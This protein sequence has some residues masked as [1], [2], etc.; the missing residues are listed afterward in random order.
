MAYKDIGDYGIIGNLET[1]ALVGLDGSID[2]LCL[3]AIDSPSVF[4]ALLDDAKGGRFAITPSG[5]PTGALSGEWTSTAA[6]IFNT[7]I[8]ETTFRTKTGTAVITDFMPVLVE[9]GGTPELY[10]RVEAT[11]GAVEFAL[12]FEPRFDYARA[13]TSV[14]AVKGGIAASGNGE[15]LTLSFTAE[16]KCGPMC[17]TATFTLKKGES[18]CFVLRHGP[19]SS[20][21]NL[22]EE[23]E[24]ALKKTEEFWL[25][26]LR[27]SETGL[28]IDLGPFKGMVDRSALVLKLL[29]YGPTGA[30]AA[31]ATTSLPEEIGGVRNWD[32]RYTWIRDTS[33]ILQALYN[34]GHLKETED[35]LRWVQGLLA[36]HGAAGMQI[37]Y[38]LR[39]ETDITEEVLAHLEGYR[40]SAPVRI[41]NEAYRQRQ[42]DIYGELMDSALK[43]SNYV[44]KID[45]GM[46]PFLRGVCDYVALNWES[47]DAG[48][49]EV[50]S[51]YRS[52]T[53]SRLMCWVALDRGVAIAKRY[54]FQT[55]LKRW[56]EVRG[57]IKSDIM[58]RGWNEQIQ[59]FVGYYGGD[60]LD[61]ATLLIPIVGLL[62]FDDPR[63]V[64]N[65]EA[66]RKGLCSEGLIY[67]YTSPDGVAG[68]EGAFLSCSFWFIDS[69]VAM[70]RCVEAESYLDRMLGY[71][72]HLG[73]FSEE[74]DPVKSVALGN[75]PQAFTHIGFINSVIALRKAQ[76]RTTPQKP[77]AKKRLLGFLE[78]KVVLNK[79][80]PVPGIKSE[81]LVRELKEAMNTLRGGYFDTA[82]GRVAYELMPGSGPYM[83]YI[84]LSGAL[85]DFDL[86]SIKGREER[87]A[88]WINIYNLLV[89]HSVVELGIRDSVTE[90]NGFFARSLYRIGGF[91]FSLDDIEH[92]ILRGN[93]RHPRSLWSPFSSTDERRALAVDPLEPRIHFALV[94]ASSSCPPIGLYTSGDIDRELTVAGEVFINS[95]GLVIDREK[96]KVSLS[97]IFQWYGRDFGHDIGA[98]LRYLSNFLYEQEDR[99][100]VSRNAGRLKVR[101][102]RYDWRLNR[103]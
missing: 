88:F 38:G 33:F 52:F 67:R 55:D 45:V 72:N 19:A 61:A 17:A 23:Y 57:Y 37:M 66:V 21:G 29:S 35:Y 1:I 86:N 79:D 73:L 36:S 83:R 41:G 31:A 15:A 68:G 94:C 34:L 93:R 62:P 20:T 16:L 75:F 13:S 39:G 101:Y 28:V 58:M 92:G 25:D 84:C 18:A 9:A 40:G 77:P 22:A 12:L 78:E 71:S 64:A 76:I 50:R 100:Y 14:E 10:R 53:Y 95:G 26:W 4:C 47:P 98:R 48:I 99:A 70:G 6:Y 63:V 74:Y 5:A 24:A 85:K 103:S 2:W 65:M 80:V 42:L 3:P 49:W 89:I 30:M 44:G 91:D 54:G 8:L 82:T 43:L 11:S 69:L 87:L 32:Y 90:V 27:K 81:E 96:F 97:S 60:G 46:W 56:E 59:A 102:Q 7:N 51:E